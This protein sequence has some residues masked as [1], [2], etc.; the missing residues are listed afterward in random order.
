MTELVSIAFVVVESLSI[1]ENAAASGIPIPRALTDVL[2][3]LREDSDKNRLPMNPSPVESHTDVHVNLPPGTP[4][5][6]VVEQ[7]ERQNKK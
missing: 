7:S 3:K 1:V 6:V 4:H 5:T 2:A